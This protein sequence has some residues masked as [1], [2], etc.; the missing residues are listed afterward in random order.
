[1]KQYLSPAVIAQIGS[2]DL[3]ARMVVEGTLA[4]EHKSRFHGFN[5]EFSEHRQYFHGDE[6]RHIDW[7]LFAKSDRYYVKQYEENTSL[8]ANILLDCSRSMAYPE[9]A[10]GGLSKLEYARY[11]A[12]ALAYLTLHQGDS[13]GVVTFSDRIRQRVV[14]RSTPN[15]LQRILAA[16]DGN[17]AADRT[18]F[19][20][21]FQEFSNHVKRR[22]LVI[23]LS[24]FFDDYDKIM[25]GVKFLKFLK[26]EL[27]L[28]QILTPQELEFPFEDYTQFVDMEDDSSLWL[29]PRIIRERY[30]GGM[31]QFIHRLGQECRFKKIDFAT[32]RTDQPFE[33][34]LAKFLAIR[35]KRRI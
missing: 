11:L 16:I 35:A 9:Q 23:V 12:A 8:R 10:A 17:E 3:V 20:R 28:L 19:F 13:V 2:L 27:I 30:R 33:L 26:H 6:L 31:E 18:D 32:F 22:G 29:D 5:I 7:K 15:H 25:Q 14:P 4:G 21:I 34:N 1:M 24:D